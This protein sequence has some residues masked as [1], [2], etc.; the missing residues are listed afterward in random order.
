P[1]VPLVATLSPDRGTVGT[2]LSVKITGVNFES[3]TTASF[4]DDVTVVSTTFTSAHELT[5]AIQIPMTAAIGPR[6]VTLTNTDGR[7]TRVRAPSPSCR[8]R[9]RL[10]SRFRGRPR[11]R[12][13]KSRATLAPRAPRP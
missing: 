2:S 12:A 13:G 3:G 10:V 6:G 5:V 4:G 7:P 9:P 1:G 8:C 11:T